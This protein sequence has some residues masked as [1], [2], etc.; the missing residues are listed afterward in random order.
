[1]ATEA[2]NVPEAS[3]Q[4]AESSQETAVIAVDEQESEP[5]EETVRFSVWDNKIDSL[6]SNSQR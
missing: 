3:P 4:V 6:R 2:V 5:A 1:M